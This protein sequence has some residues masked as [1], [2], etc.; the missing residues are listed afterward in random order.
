MVMI[1]GGAGLILGGTTS[2]LIRRGVGWL[3]GDDPFAGDSQRCGLAF[4]GTT[5]SP[6]LRS[7]PLPLSGNVINL[8]N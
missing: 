8:R 4:R 1:R 6:L 7:G 3:S 5:P 2:T